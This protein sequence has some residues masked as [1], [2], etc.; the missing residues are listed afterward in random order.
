MDRA[1]GADPRRCWC[2]ARTCSTRARVSTGDGDLLV[3]AGEIAELGEPGGARGARGRGGSRGRGPARAAGLRGSARPPADPRPGGRGGRGHRHARG[4]GR[5][6]L[7]DPGDAEHRPGRGLRARPALAARAGLAPGASALR[8]P[9]RDHAGPARGG[10][11]RDGGARGRRSVRLHRRRPAA[12][13]G[14]RHA[15]GPPVPAARRR[16]ARAARG[17]PDALRSGGHARGQGLGAAR[18]DRDPVGVGVH[19]DRPRRRACPLRGR[20]HPHPARLGARVGRRRRAGEGG[21]R[22]S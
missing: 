12:P 13:L 6:V 16:R 2:A 17:G 18:A 7:R 9:G 10:A 19:D 20:S 1:D 11:D 21:R 4:G 15:P 22:A 3:R 8:L 14:G 5:R